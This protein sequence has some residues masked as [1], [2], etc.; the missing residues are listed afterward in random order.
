MEIVNK[1]ITEIRPYEKNPRINDDSVEAVARSIE[2]FGF[3]VPIVI[4]ADGVI[5]TG[6]TRLKAAKYLGLDEVPCIVAS[7]LTKAQIKAFRLADNKVGETSYWDMDL[8]SSELDDLENIFDMSDFG[9]ELFD[10]EDDYDE[11]EARHQQNA[12]ATQE[13]VENILNLGVCHFEGVGQYDIPEL[14]PVTHLPDVEEWI[15]F[16]YALSEKHPEN[17]GVHFF[18]DDYQFERI[19]NDPE[20]YCEILSRFKC[21][22]TP[23]FS[24]YG[25]MPAATQ[26]FNHY[27]KHWCGA[28]WQL[29]GLTVIP[30]IRASTD[31]RCYD[32]Y[33]DGEPKGG[34][35]CISSMWANK[36]PEDFHKEYTTMVENLKPK[37]V[38]IYGNHVPGLTDGAILIPKFTSKFGKDDE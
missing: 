30:T 28:F 5:V 23:D 26:I 20:R 24:P 22:L 18:V 10:E 34:V 13:R 25:D 27:R 11:E 9:F 3:K 35:V 4:D 32:W 38:L 29:R 21:V 12:N 31:P 1:K 16:N 33:L 19:W 7:D 17:K 36:Y 15:G 37:Q 8:L 14:N 2:E 6:H